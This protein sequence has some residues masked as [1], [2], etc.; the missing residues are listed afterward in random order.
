MEEM[1]MRISQ[2]VH[3]AENGDFSRNLTLDGG[4]L[5]Y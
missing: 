2:D 5:L 1:P 4:I 3:Y